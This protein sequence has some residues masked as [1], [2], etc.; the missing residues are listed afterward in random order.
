MT[1]VTCDFN[2]ILSY[3]ALYSKAHEEMDNLIVLFI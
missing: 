2:I 1:N 3:Y